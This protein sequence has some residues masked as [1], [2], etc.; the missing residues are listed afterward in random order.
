MTKGKMIVKKSCR[1]CGA[2]VV[3][4]GQKYGTPPAPL[5]SI[6]KVNPYEKIIKLK[7]KQNVL[8]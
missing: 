7:E 4:K 5:C 3:I 1:K 6:C 8:G 2:K